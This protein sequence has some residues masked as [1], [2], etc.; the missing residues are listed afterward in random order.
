MHTVLQPH[1]HLNLPSRLPACAPLWKRRANWR[2]AR[3]DLGQLAV[4]MPLSND[5]IQDGGKHPL[6]AGG[7]S[8]AYPCPRTGLVSQSQS[9]SCWVGASPLRACISGLPLKSEP[10]HTRPQATAGRA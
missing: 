1:L 10:A 7:G 6:S 4:P 3:P 8:K 2:T 9:M 5:L